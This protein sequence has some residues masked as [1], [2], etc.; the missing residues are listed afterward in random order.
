MRVAGRQRRRAERA[1]LPASLRRLFWDH[2]AAKLSWRRDR[3]L[4]LARVLGQ[5]G[6]REAQALRARLGDA[7]IREWLLR[8]R[9]RGL[10]PSRIRFWE[11]I[12][13]IAHREADAWVRAARRSPWHD[14]AR[15]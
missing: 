11:L 10:S 6:W 15:R 13:G 9:G 7:A 12:L 4:I 3:D 2:D 8:R 1:G 14:R 5:G